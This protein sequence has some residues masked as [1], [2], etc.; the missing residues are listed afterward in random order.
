MYDR[1]EIV[2]PERNVSVEIVRAA[3]EKEFSHRL[4]LLPTER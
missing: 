1:P 3:D 2:A 4:R